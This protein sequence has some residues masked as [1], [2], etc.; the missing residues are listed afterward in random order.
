MFFVFFFIFIQFH[1][2]YSF[3]LFFLRTLISCSN[4]IAQSYYHWK[5]AE[6]YF[7]LIIFY[8]HSMLLLIRLDDGCPPIASVSPPKHVPLPEV[9]RLQEFTAEAFFLFFSI[10]ALGLQY[11]NLYRTAFWVPQSNTKYAMV[12][13]AHSPLFFI[14]ICVFVF[15]I[16]L[17]RGCCM[18]DKF[19]LESVFTSSRRFL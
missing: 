6:K 13:D 10:G 8:C 14:Y 17:G 18:L 15:K 9:P 16:F 19:V 2:L 11:L 1:L 7:N 5:I 3:F 12:I 4:I